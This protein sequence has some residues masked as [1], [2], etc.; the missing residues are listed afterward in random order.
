MWYVNSTPNDS[1]AYSP[2]QSTSFDGAI[3]LTDEQSDMLVRHNG[4]V[5]ITSEHRLQQECCGNHRD[6]DAQHRGLG[7]MEGR[8]SARAGAGA[9]G[10]GTAAGGRGLFG[11]YDGGGAMSVYELARKYYPR[12][13]DDARIDALVQAGRLTQEEREQ[14]RRAAQGRA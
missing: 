4:F 6:G 3:P 11:C 1:G 5:F 7:G 13:W 12:L 9:H 2:P 14:L 8:P 10:G